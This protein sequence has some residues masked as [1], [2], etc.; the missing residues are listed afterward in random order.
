MEKL[1]GEWGPV[2]VASP[3][4]TNTAMF[5]LPRL[6]KCPTTKSRIPSQF[7]S[8]VTMAVGSGPTGIVCEI[9]KPP[10]PFPFKTLTSFD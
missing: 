6:L 1:V 2:A 10:V 8:P 5:W 4:P 7:R 3:L 9:V